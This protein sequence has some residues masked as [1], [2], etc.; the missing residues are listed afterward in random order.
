[1]T[2]GLPLL[3]TATLVVLAALRGEVEP[4]VRAF[5]AVT[6]AYVLLLVG[7]V[8]VF[9]VGY[10]DHVSERYLVTALPP[11]LLGLC[12]WIARGAPR[13]VAVAVP[14][15]VAA[16]VAV[17]T[18]PPDRVGTPGSAHDALTA[19]PF[20]QI[21]DPGDAAFHLGFAAFAILAA[22]AF[23][24]LPRRLLPVAVAVLGVA[25]VSISALAAREIERFSRVERALDFGA[26][27]P[28]WIDAAGVSPVLLVDTGEL[29]AT[30]APR[31]TFWNRSV[32]LLA[33]LEGVPEQALPQTPLRIRSDGAL[34]DE[35]REEV[36]APYAALPA[37][38][39]A[40]GERLAASVP[41]EIA[42]ASTLW[43]VREP[44]RLVSRSGGFTPVGDF[45]LGTVVVYRCGPG[46]LRLR[47]LGKDGFPVRIKVNGFPWQTVELPANGV[48]S[49]SV[50]AARRRRRHSVPVRARERRARRLDARRVGSGLGLTPLRA[51]RPLRSAPRSRRARRRPRIPR[52]AP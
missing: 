6:A 48:W 30:A 33:R 4:A 45:R 39:V 16:I 25:F 47:L 51:P 5:L 28:S 37:S 29:P 26:V 21:A 13:P 12:V 10:L 34:V 36:T 18:L 14:L 43:R 8:S 52:R 35:R 24:F 20:V 19:L 2:L 50:R 40:D 22:A 3:A 23:L 27:D 11:L 32:R 9:A 38:M 44:L 15:A 41:T 46:V 17:T 49:G 31:T 7:Q 42:P 1:M